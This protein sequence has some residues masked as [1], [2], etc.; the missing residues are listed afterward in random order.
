[1]SDATAT[2]SNTASNATGSNGQP[3]ESRLIHDWN[4]VGYNRQ[5]SRK[6][7]CVDDETLRDGLQNP[8]VK[9]PSLEQKFEIVRLQAK[10][11]ITTV[12]VG[13]PGAGPQAGEHCDALI[14]LIAQE[15]LPIIPRC[16][17]RTLEVDIAPIVDFQQKHGIDVYCD[18][19]IGS[20]P[21]RQYAE[22]WTIE[23][24][25]DVS[26]KA[27]QFTKKNNIPTMFVT[28][29]TIRARPGDLRQLFV[30]AIEEG[31]KRLCL[32]D[33]VGHAT[34]NGVYQLVTWTQN[35]LIEL[36]VEN[37]VAI[38]WHGH[39][40]RGLDIPNSLSAI[41]AGADQVHACALGIGERAGNTAMEI[42]LINL[43][44]LGAWDHDLTA[45][46]EYCRKVSDAVGVP[47]PTNYPVV[48]ADAFETG[49]GVHAAAVIKAY[50]KGHDWLADRVY[51][52]VPAAFVG[53]RQRIRVGF[54]SGKSNVTWVLKEMGIEPT[55]AI[56]DR[57]LAAAKESKTL[58]TDSQVRELAT[59]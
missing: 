57:I 42:L 49:T 18:A 38:D 54:M 59:G 45:L 55:E 22:N 40:D 17:C 13:L 35:L 47:I 6:K 8:S 5:F 28:E 7:V 58:L 30:M 19:F 29:D 44:L 31:A 20:S 12:D 52:G 43:K 33:T 14:G 41:E 21:I 53:R 2:A 34:P 36:G 50:D 1:M 9:N 32:C 23:K 24:M 56:V 11:G 46:T 37:D 4:L 26:R 25:M 51:S 39:R 10:L 3:D 48:G 27:L 16:A 15:K